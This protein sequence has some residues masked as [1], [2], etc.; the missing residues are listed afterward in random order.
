MEQAGT[1]TLL[2]YTFQSG[3]EGKPFFTQIS[4]IWAFRQLPH[5]VHSSSLL[6][7]QVAA[8]SVPQTAAFLA[9]AAFSLN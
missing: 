8:L 2:S 9:T 3:L 1:W 6:L 7:V 5:S 4:R